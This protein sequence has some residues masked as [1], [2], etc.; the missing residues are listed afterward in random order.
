MALQGGALAGAV[1]GGL[2][3]CILFIALLLF[4]FRMWMQG[5][6][7]NS[8]VSLEGKV[9]VI[10]GANTGIGKICALDMAKRG[11]K[12]ILL[13]R[14]QE[15]GEAAAE[16]IRKETKAEVIFHKCDLASLASV[17]ECAEQLNNSLPKIDI[18]L[19]N[20][21]VMMCPLTR[22]E[23]GFEM[24]IG[25]N[26]LGHFLLTNLL[27]PLLK[28]AAP[29]ARI[30]NVSSLAHERGRMNFDDIN[31][32]KRSYSPAGAYGQSKL[33][34]VLFTRELAR[35]GEGSGVNAYA[36]HPGV[37][38]TELGRHLNANPVLKCMSMM[39][40]PLVKT[41][42]AGA[43]T[44]LYCC[45]EQSISDENGKYYSDC[46]RKEPAVQAQNDE[47]AKKLWQISEKL[48]GLAQN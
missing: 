36:L 1:I 13:C 11:G 46:R 45:L 29:D 22:T 48:T 8:K 19:N 10:T 43:Q 37:I 32:E 24:Q 14:S 25:T 21:G 40:M 3:A 16:E 39:F 47:D 18:L 7:C 42:E 15:R 4:L 20:A 31:Y 17:R 33:A 27:M 26:H 5:P 12:I 23:D 44:S 9:V 6:K 38:A 34:N 2:I 30:V 28:R 35:K 41:P